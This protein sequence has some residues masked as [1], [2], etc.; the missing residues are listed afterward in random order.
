[1]K[2]NKIKE[3]KMAKLR[4]IPILKDSSRNEKSVVFVTVRTEIFASV[5]AITDRA[6]QSFLL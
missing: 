3:E 4:K 5:F 1:M 6:K 2:K